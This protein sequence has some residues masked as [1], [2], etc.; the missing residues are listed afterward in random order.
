MVSMVLYPHIRKNYKVVF[1]LLY[2]V[3]K[4]YMHTWSK[5]LLLFGRGKIDML[6]AKINFVA[7]AY[8]YASGLRVQIQKLSFELKSIY[9]ET[10]KAS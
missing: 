2:I 7:Y 1:I 10:V 6:N 8:A 4:P 3:R 9:S 5:Q